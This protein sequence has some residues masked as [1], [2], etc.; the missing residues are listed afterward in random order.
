M[1]KLQSSI[2]R[3]FVS[4][5]LTASIVICVGS[6]APVTIDNDSATELT[7]QISIDDLP[8]R[9]ERTLQTELKGRKL[10]SNDNAAWQIMHGVIC[11]GHDLPLETPD[12]GQVPALDYAFHEGTIRGW[13]LMPGQNLSGDRRG[14]KAQLEPGSYTGQGHVDQW[15]AIC[16]MAELP[17]TDTLGIDGKTYTLL[18]WAEQARLDACY[19]PLNEFS[20]TLIALTYYFPN[21]PQWTTNDGSIWSWE[22]M[23]E[24]EVAYDLNES[25]CGGAH[26]LVG[27]TRALQAKQRLKLADS[28]AWEATRRKVDQALLDI[29]QM[30]CRDG[31]LSSHYLERPGASRDLGLTLASTGHLF[32]F[33]AVAAGTETLKSDWVRAAASR[34]CEIFEAT[35]HEDLDCGACYHALNGLKVYRNRLLNNSTR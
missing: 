17:P 34:L 8:E 27:L 14:V 32:E 30:R 31:S 11:Y 18:D 24:Y 19:N 9:I 13:H 6:C 7:S 4:I 29:E 3:S 25:P 20:W 5:L 1:P 23:L 2:A 33:L 21:D 26:R 28:P 22:R 35:R 15:I 10:T 12:R 16:A